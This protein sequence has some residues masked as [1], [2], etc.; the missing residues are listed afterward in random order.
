MRSDAPKVGVAGWSY[1]DWV[2][3][4]YPAN[5][6]RKFDRLAFLAQYFELLEVNS[7]F[8][9]CPSRRTVER[10]AHRAPHAEFSAKLPREATHLRTIPVKTVIVEF[11][12][13]FKPLL[14]M[15]R[16]G[17]V[18]AQFP[19]SFTFGPDSR[20]HVA[21]IAKR[22]SHSVHTVVEVRHPSWFTPGAQEFF[23]EHSIDVAY[24]DMPNRTGS[25]VILGT[26][27]HVYVRLHGRNQ[28]AWFRPGVGRD[29]KYDYLYDMKTLRRWAEFGRKRSQGGQ[30]VR[31]ITNNHFSGQAVVN[32]FQ[33]RAFLEGR[34]VRAPKNLIDWY[35]DLSG[36][37]EPDEIDDAGQGSLFGSM[38]Q[39]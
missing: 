31:I 37:A 9:G 13:A 4:V 22:L 16:L 25:E 11:L 3:P 36:I 32:A 39:D 14:E 5:P 18:L 27:R 12:G 19:F 24:L 1:E 28:S 6:G 7:S 17:T 35:A 8:Y 15:G 38:E 34:K 26:G 29:A 21:E 30:A 10:W 33:M 20:V 23:A 2:G